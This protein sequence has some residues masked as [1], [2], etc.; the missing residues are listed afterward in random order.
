MEAEVGGT[1]PQAQ[2]HLGHQEL[3]GTG[4]DAPWS[5]WR[6]WDLDVGLP[7]SRTRERINFCCFKLPVRGYLSQRPQDTQT[8]AFGEPARHTAGG[9]CSGPPRGE[10][11]CKVLHAS[12]PGSFSMQFPVDVGDDMLSS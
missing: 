4:R 5:L 11:A 3:E 10:R 1:R 9:D 7:A 12:Q 8:S 2:G 6:E